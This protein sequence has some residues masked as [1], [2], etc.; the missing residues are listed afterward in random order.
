M[1]IAFLNPLEERLK[2]FPAKYLAGH[3]VLTTTDKTQPPAGYET[4]EAI[5]WSDYPVDAALIDRMPNLRF[6]QR[7]GLLRAKGDARRA[8]EKGVPVSVLPYG[9][10]DRVS[11]HALA[12]TLDVLRKVTR[13]DEAVRAGV[14]PD[15]LPEE[16]TTYPATALNWSRLPQV[17]TINDKTV[18]II[19]FG[20]MGACFARMVTP[21]NCRVLY[22]KRSR[23]TPAQEA[24]YGVEYATLDD[25][26]PQAD[27]VVSFV[28]FSPDNRKMM[29]AA[30]FALMKPSA[31]FINVGRGNTVDAL[32]DALQGRRIAG[33][34]LD[35]FSVEP[36]PA[37]NP[38]RSLD[39]VVLTPHS[40]GGIQGWMNTFERLAE[41]LR[42]V[43]AGKQVLHPM[44]ADDPQP[45]SPE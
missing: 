9:L 13:G 29:G 35:V 8:V 3:E 44:Q 7:I 18:G 32:I 19:G 17:D 25:L 45:G 2:D 34:G 41:N 43:E 6:M 42:R 11:L 28:P 30:Q 23:L 36:L 39:N 26:L 38:L 31:Y 21:F 16:E 4:A 10:S 15:N 12:L 22:N 24:Y 14:N 20:E 40:A 33:A 1:R 37:D 27:L 5:V